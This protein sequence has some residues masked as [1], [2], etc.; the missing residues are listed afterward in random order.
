MLSSQRDDSRPGSRPELPWFRNSPQPPGR[1]I[2]AGTSHSRD[3]W[4]PRGSGCTEP[5][6]PGHVLEATHLHS[7]PK[8]LKRRVIMSIAPI[9]ARYLDQHV[10]YDVVLHEP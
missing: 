6:N 1:L 9:L 10:S 3:G 2:V 5:G 4:P 8:S 7:V